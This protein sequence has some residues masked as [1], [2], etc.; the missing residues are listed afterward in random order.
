MDIDQHWRT[1]SEQRRAIAD[2]LATLTPAELD[3]PSLCDGWRIRDVAAHV[4]LAAQP[5][6]PLG[7]LREAARA[8]GSFHRLN[9]DIAVRHADAVPDPVA[10]LRAVAD[11]RRLPA[12]TNYRNIH[13]DV[14]VHAQD[15]ARPLGRVIA[16]APESAAVAA[17]RVW[18]MGWPFWAKR[19]FADVTLVAEDSAWTAG[20]GPELRGSTLDLLM[21]LTGRHPAL[22]GPG[23]ERL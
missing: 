3:S 14:I 5:P 16:V 12:V 9:H 11:S 4:A 1:I 15:I 13:Y 19:R 17:Q 7:M 22:T 10:D 23:V 6:G 20:S 21:L 8:R 18:T 2:L